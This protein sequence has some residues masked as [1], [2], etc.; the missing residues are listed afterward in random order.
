MLFGISIF[1]NS[2]FHYYITKKM[3]GYEVMDYLICRHRQNLQL[4]DG[5]G[6]G[7]I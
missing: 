6:T 7:S 5:L 3:E 4:T 2:H 1:P